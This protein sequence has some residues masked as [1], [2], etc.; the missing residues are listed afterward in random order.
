MSRRGRPRPRR[1]RSRHRRPRRRVRPPRGTAPVDGAGRGLLPRCGRLPHSRFSPPSRFHH[2]RRSIAIRSTSIPAVSRRYF[3]AATLCVGRLSIAEPEPVGRVRAD[4]DGEERQD[5]DADEE[6]DREHRQRFR[7]GATK[8]ATL[9]PASSSPPVS[10]GLAERVRETASAA[11]L[12][13]AASTTGRSSATERPTRGSA[14]T[15]DAG[16]L[17][18]SAI[19]SVG[20]SSV[21][22]LTAQPTSPASSSRGR[23]PEFGSRRPVRTPRRRH[24]EQTG[25]SDRERHPGVRAAP[26]DSR[27]TTVPRSRSIAATA[28]SSRRR[29][30]A[31]ARRRGSDRR[32]RYR[33]DR[34]AAPRS[35]RPHRRARRGGLDRGRRAGPPCRGRRVD[36]D[37]VERGGDI[38]RERRLPTPPF[39]PATAR[40]TPVAPA[41]RS[42]RRSLPRAPK[43][44]THAPQLSESLRVRG[45][46][47]VEPGEC[48]DAIGFRNHFRRRRQIGLGQPLRPVDPCLDGVQ[49]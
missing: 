22:R 44:S 42:A 3:E 7:P 39:P 26:P 15:T 13:G 18:A 23:A 28:D 11:A 9:R 29:S 32:G 30:A 10:R 31:R 38:V 33:P 20:G 48:S 40:I 8:G 6:R 5:G 37:R 16:A 34:R 35:N 14:G 25:V 24:D 19:A 41:P 43:A 17:M 47:I 4:L 36:D 49:S 1:D 46:A 12:S 2:P 21:T 27:G 45:D